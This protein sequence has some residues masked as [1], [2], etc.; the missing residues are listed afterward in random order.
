MTSKPTAA[1]GV[2][3]AGQLAYEADCAIEPNYHDGTLRPTWDR[4]PEYAR[5]SWERN[6]TVKPR[7]RTGGQG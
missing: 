5:W 4:M 3:S 2:K 7:K 1:G 6:P